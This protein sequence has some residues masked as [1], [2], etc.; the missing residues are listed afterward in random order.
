MRKSIGNYGTFYF[1]PAFLP[2][3][4]LVPWLMTVIGV[5]VGAAGFSIPALWQKHKQIILGTSVFCFVVAMSVF[6]YSLPDAEVRHQGTRLIQQADFPV[7]HLYGQPEAVKPGSMKNFGEIWS[8][9]VQKHIFSS[10]VIAG[11]LLIYGSYELSIE[12]ISRKNGKPVWSL[13]QNDFVFSL[14]KGK[15]GTIYAGEGLHYTK[16]ASLT[17]LDAQ[18]GKINWRREFLGHIEELPALDEASGRLWTGTGP[19]GLWALDSSNASVLWH[20]AL[21]HIDSMPLVLDGVLYVPAQIDENIHKT[22]FFALNAKSGKILWELPQPGQPWGSPLINK[23]EKI[24]LT[25]TGRGQIG[26][27]KKTDKGWAHAVSLKGKQL[28]R[29]E[30]PGMPLQPAIYLSQDDLVIYTI[31]TGEIVALNVSDGS[32][33][34]QAKAGEKFMAPA[35]L[36]SHFDEPM[37]ATTSGDGIF[38]IRNARTGDALA[39]RMVGKDVAASPV[40]DGDI[41]YVMTKSEV[42]AFGGLGSLVEKK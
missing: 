29:T 4:E 5:V 14:S 37:I 10:P 30:L 9:P 35:T 21:G 3:I 34:W 28:W 22:V 39:R 23:T 26:A 7:V 16:A 18:T 13:P 11:D 41:I 1:F 17:S 33:A 2:L 32:V 31:K 36:I 6:A 19:G 20:K 15:D 40:A 38:S 42:T 8:V 25:T 24:I 27:T 12:A